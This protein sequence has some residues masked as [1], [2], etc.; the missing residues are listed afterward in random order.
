MSEPIETDSSIG[1]Y[2]VIS[3]IGAGGIGLQRN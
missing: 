2:R 3:K 1:N